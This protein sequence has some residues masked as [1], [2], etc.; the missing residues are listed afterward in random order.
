L[1]AHSA[2]A[3][4]ALNCRHI[5]EIPGTFLCTGDDLVIHSAF[6]RAE[7][8]VEHSHHSAHDL[9]SEDLNAFFAAADEACKTYP[10]SC[11]N[12][13]EI[14]LRRLVK[15]AELGFEKS[16]FLGIPRGIY[17]PF[18]IS[19]ELR[20]ARFFLNKNYHDVVVEFWNDLSGSQRG[21]VTR[22]LEKKYD[23]SVPDLLINEFQAYVLQD[24]PSRGLLGSIA[25][26]Y[27]SPL[28]RALGENP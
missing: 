20:H 14:F 11:L 3:R 6:S 12:G 8:F 17:L 22:L 15:K 1:P 13:D 9:R 7:F 28:L 5:P 21:A 27:K 25:Y 10:D 24:E 23:V 26:Q 18:M 4:E 16:V 19:H 2:F